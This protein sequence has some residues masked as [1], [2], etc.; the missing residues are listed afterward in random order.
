MAD[1]R[2]RIE[3]TAA[4]A[5]EIQFTT[6]RLLA[7]PLPVGGGQAGPFRLDALSETYIR[8]TE[9]NSQTPIDARVELAGG[10][11]LLRFRVITGP[12]SSV[13]LW[14][15]ALGPIQVGA[16]SDQVF[17]FIDGTVFP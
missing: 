8:V 15:G 3:F 5:V 6:G 13:N 2:F 12:G 10:P 1:G 14:P 17:E 16:G 4:D 11:T 7:F 9:A